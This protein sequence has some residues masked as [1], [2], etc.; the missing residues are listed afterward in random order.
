VDSSSRS[1]SGENDQRELIGG[2]FGG[3]SYNFE[4]TNWKNFKALETN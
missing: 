4:K 3:K 2:F 1:E